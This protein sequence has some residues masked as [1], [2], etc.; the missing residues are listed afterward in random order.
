M[1]YTPVI[2]PFGL[3]KLN[4]TEY[5]S[6]D[7]KIVLRLENEI[8]T[9]YAYYEVSESGGF[10]WSQNISKF[11]KI[12]YYEN[13][14]YI[15][16]EFSGSNLN[17]SLLIY[18]DFSYGYI[19]SPKIENSILVRLLLLDDKIENFSKIYDKNNIKIYSLDTAFLNKDCYW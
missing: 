3:M 15:T 14:E 16:H 6:D 4:K 11:N 19:I 5:E 8:W 7:R 9:P 1:R 18:Y 13:N 12:I 2:Q 10:K 17:W